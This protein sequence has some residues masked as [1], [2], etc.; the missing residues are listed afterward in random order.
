M[1]VT[2]ADTAMS[3][4]APVPPFRERSRLVDRILDCMPAASYSMHALLRLVDIVETE[5]VPC[6]AVECLHAPR[7]LVNPR[8]VERHANTP[9][10]LL[11][12]VMH[13]LHHIILGH[14]RQFARPTRA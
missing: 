9:E 2:P 7:M 8:F 14:T 11:M 5:S 4:P 6:A 13:E 1:T 10:K 12:L 3:A